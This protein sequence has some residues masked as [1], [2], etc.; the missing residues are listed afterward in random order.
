MLTED[1]FREVIQKAVDE[2][3]SQKALALANG[4]S[5]SV[6]S[7]ILSGRRSISD[8][9]AQMFGRRL[10]RLYVIPESE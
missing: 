7:E 2:A 8:G 6:L 10:V 9:V 1:E 5:V 4:L 3:G